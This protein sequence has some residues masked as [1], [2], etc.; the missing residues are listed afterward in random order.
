MEKGEKLAMNWIQGSERDPMMSH[1]FT[2]Y[3]AVSEKAKGI[4]KLL[5]I[6]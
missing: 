6:K 4:Q 2:I 1:I 3:R 5:A